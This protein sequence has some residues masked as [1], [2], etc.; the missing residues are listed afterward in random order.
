MLTTPD[1]RLALQAYDRLLEL[2][3]GAELK[4]GDVI[5]ERRMAE[6][7]DM[8]RTPVRDAL[9]MLEGEGLLIRYGRA[10]Q[11]K[12]MRIEDFMDTLQIR[13]LLE[14]ATARMAA[15][16]MAAEEIA[17]LRADLEQVLASE[18]DGRADRALVRDIDERLH[19]G[20]ADAAGNPQLGQLIRTLRRQT[21][22][23]DLRAVPE[24]LAD[25]CREHSIILDA[26][27]GGDGE[28]AAAEMSAH[29][30]GVRDSI[31]KRLSR[32]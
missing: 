21:Q 16:H 2:I 10:L 31:I 8:S 22:M 4:P 29:L 18:V 7:L 5:N 9:L 19:G 26:I 11:V 17:A 14:P 27:A 12:Q 13:M 23:F 1:K 30:Q 6:L 15:G 3:Q 32:A 25:T 28:A 24:R 20:I